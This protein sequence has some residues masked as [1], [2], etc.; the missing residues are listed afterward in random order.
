MDLDSPPRFNRRPATSELLHH[1]FPNEERLV[2]DG[3]DSVLCFFLE[4][5]LA[6]AALDDRGF[7]HQEL[8]VNVSDSSF[9]HSPVLLNGCCSK[10]GSFVS[11][12]HERGDFDFLSNFLFVDDAIEKLLFGRPFEVVISSSQF[13]YFATFDVT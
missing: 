1:F 9:V 13:S 5:V 2:R 10:D 3:F 11:L 12:E 6:E 4:E 7:G 8:K